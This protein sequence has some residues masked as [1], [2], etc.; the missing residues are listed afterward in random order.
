M[1]GKGTRWFPSA[2]APLRVSTSHASTACRRWRSRT[3]RRSRRARASTWRTRRGGDRDGSSAARFASHTAAW[4][5][6]R[7]W[8]DGSG[9]SRAGRHVLAHA[10]GAAPGD[11][12]SGP[13]PGAQNGRG[14]AAAADV[15]ASRDGAPG[16]AARCQ[17]SDTTTAGGRG[18]RVARSGVGRNPAPCPARRAPRPAGSRRLGA[19]QPERAPC[20]WRLRQVTPAGQSSL[21]DAIVWPH[22]TDGFAIERPPTATAP[23]RKATPWRASRRATARA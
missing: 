16:S 8:V 9:R 12:R 17:L 11:E 5:G 13:K 4:P 22:R 10:A 15:A 23:A 7:Q 6:R 1:N 14:G 18:D 3:R 21:P 2:V 20:G 19:R